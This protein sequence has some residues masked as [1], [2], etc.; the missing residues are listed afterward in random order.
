MA[1]QRELT[2]GGILS[3]LRRDDAGWHI[4]YQGLTLRS[5]FQPVVSITHKRIVGYEA[6]LR[7]TDQSGRALRPDTVFARAPGK[8][9]ALAFERLARCVHFANF[10]E[11]NTRT[12]A[13]TLTSLAAPQGGDQ[14]AW[15]GPARTDGGW[16]FVNALP[17]LFRTGWSYTSFID[18]LCDHFGL[19]PWRVVIEMIEEPAADE[20]LFM[21]TVEALRE[22]QLLIAIDDFGTGFS[23]FDRI[24]HVRPDI[25]KLDRSL[26]ARMAT[27]GADPQF[28]T[29]LVTMLHRAGTLVLGEGVENEAEM[30]TLMEADTDFI[31]GYW[32]GEPGAS[33]DAAGRAA[34]PAIDA[35]WERFRA[36]AGTVPRVPAD[37]AEF[38]ATV[39]AGARVYADTRD[40]A[41]AARETF[42]RSPARRVFVLDADGEQ[43]Q[44]SITH[45]TAPK[46]ARLWPLFPDT[47]SNWSRRAYFRRALAAPG[48]VA[49]MGPHYSLTEGKDCYTA[50]VAIEVGG[51]TQVF[52]VDFA[53]NGSSV[54]LFDE[55]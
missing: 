39:L 1:S 43:H 17:R 12:V 9:A 8:G 16:L 37:F 51:V 47:Y 44:P 48:R 27:P 31:Q 11:Q 25:V 22:R 42:A 13:P 40:L 18:E 54:R 49:V 46:P 6:L 7:A 52:C 26:V 3:H 32:L 35:M 23:N 34:A 2:L 15:G 21:R 33:L 20:G 53:P 30:L 41:L 14:C 28:A 4:V 24:W 10:A 50:A 36:H 19:P 45:E 38:E 29:Q 5:V 55:S